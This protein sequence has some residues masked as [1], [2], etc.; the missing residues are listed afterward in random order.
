MGK[1]RHKEACKTVHGHVDDMVA[2]PC[3]A[4]QQVEV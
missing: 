3:K 2:V 1:M 4:V